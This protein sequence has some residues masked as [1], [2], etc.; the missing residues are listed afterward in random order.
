ME[1]SRSVPTLPMEGDGLWGPMDL[2]CEAR[3]TRSPASPPEHHLLKTLSTAPLL[4]TAQ[5]QPPTRGQRW[6]LPQGNSS[7][8]LT[9]TLK[10]YCDIQG[11]SVRTVL[12][13]A[14]TANLSVIR[15]T[16]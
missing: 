6:L 4:S 13:T 15:L 12:E 11:H 8:S 9:C 14:E 2:L 16:C 7:N 3:Q 10:G 5:A 1:N